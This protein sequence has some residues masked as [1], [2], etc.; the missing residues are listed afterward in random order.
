M[1]KNVILIG[2]YYKDFDMYCFILFYFFF[3]KMIACELQALS[4]ILTDLFLKK[5]MFFFLFH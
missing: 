4:T 1:T 3:G 5:N 2:E